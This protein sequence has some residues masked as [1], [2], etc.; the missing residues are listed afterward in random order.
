MTKTKTLQE[1]IERHV[2]FRPIST[3]W[4]VGKCAACN[5]YKERAG[6]KFEAG[7][8]AYN[9]WNCSSSM[10]YEEFSGKISGRFRKILLSYGIDDSEINSAVNSSFFAGTVKPAKITL[11]SLSK[12]NSENQT[13]KLPS[14]SLRLGVSTEFSDYQEKLIQYLLNR[15]IDLFKYHFFFSL[16]ERFKNRIIIPFYKNGNLIYWQARSINRIE[17]KRYDNAPNSRE[18]ILYN[19]DAL[20]TFSK[21]PLFVSE[22][23]FD[24]MMF[25]GVA[26]L[27]SDLNVSKTK[28]LKQT[29]RRLVFV[30][31]KDKNGKHLAEEVLRNGWEIT[32]VPD[33]A[34]DLNESVCRFGVTW[35]AL[36]IM[37]N[38][39]KNRSH[40]QLA[41]NM[42]CR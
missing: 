39:P 12:S 26:L 6:F 24:A 5:D 31:D 11:E 33:G 17:K 2:H 20:S 3:G 27:G 4:V 18:G 38:I 29:T 36:K 1:V 21:T 14:K 30:I 22:G 25:D 23:V 40:A 9:C 16:E 10:Q 42:N 28:L 7:M 15:K 19:V 35:T 37:D 32:F 8:V 41:I 34:A 13:I